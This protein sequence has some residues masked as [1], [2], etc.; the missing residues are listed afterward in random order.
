MGIELTGQYRLYWT[1][2]DWRTIVVTFMRMGK[3]IAAMSLAVL[4]VAGGCSKSNGAG[5]SSGSGGPGGGGRAR[6]V[7]VAAVKAVK[8]A[9]PIQVGDFGSTIANST[10]TIRPQVTGS[11]TKVTFKKGEN[12]KKGQL[13][14]EIDP[15]PFEASLQQAQASVARDSVQVEQAKVDLARVG[16]LLKKKISSQDEY[17]KAKSVLDSLEATVR[18]DQA[19][20]ENMKLQRAY[21]EIRCPID[22]RAGDVL[23]DEGNVIKANETALVMVN[24]IRP[25]EVQFAIPQTALPAVRQRMA[26]GKLKVSVTVPGEEGVEEG[27]LTFV[28][29]TIDKTTGRVLLAATVPN[30]KERFWP[31]RHVQVTL[32]LAVIP[33]AVVVP[34]QAIQTGR[35]GKYVYV[36]KGPLKGEKPV[37]EAEFRPVTMGAVRESLAVIEKGVSDG[38]LVVTDGHLRLIAG[39]QAEIKSAASRPASGPSGGEGILPV[40]A[41]GGTP[42]PQ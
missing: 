28:D 41:A 26:E 19:A 32:T 9:F 20:V 14:F 11:L 34:T 31:G 21:C 16:E 13:L 25:I 18:A 38:E 10:V 12:L 36:L 1:A 27:E 2:Q 22:G 42:T 6:P 7:P 8:Q 39:G 35:D 23:V 3:V 37:Y 15:R 30:E 5:T 40:S 4:L 24:Q 17:D 33:D 29:N